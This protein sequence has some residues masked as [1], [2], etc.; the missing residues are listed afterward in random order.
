ML[1]KLRSR[2]SYANVM[3]TLG[4]FIA[5][6]GTAYAVNTVGST[7]IID[8]QVKSV[9]VGD[10]EINS[11]DVK[12]QTLNTFDVHSF[13]GVDVVDGSLTGDD[14]ANTSSL[15]TQ[16]IH[17]EELLFNN[18]LN[19]SDIGAGAVGT[20]EVAD[21][22]LTGFDIMDGFIGQGELADGAVNSAKTADNSLTGTDINE[23]TLNMPP[24]TTATFSGATGE[25]RSSDGGFKKV[26]S[27]NLPA[28]SYAVVATVNLDVFPGGA[29]THVTSAICELRN[30]TGVIGGA[31]DRRLRPDGDSVFRSMTMNGGAQVPAGGGEVS[32]WCLTQDGIE[33]VYTQVMFIR[34]DGF[35]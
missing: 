15:G 1:G 26:N 4:V 29:G 10:N 28:G 14:L 16:D 9:D 11:A 20:S 27:R 23:S 8:G 7:D 32:V 18:T 33:T 21:G 35:F 22:S 5:L 31:T 12:D 30:G 19:S 2:L 3:A 25:I 24:T 17:E 34:L 13:L 6:G